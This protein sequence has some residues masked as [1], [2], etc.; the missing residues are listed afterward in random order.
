MWE[1]NYSTFYVCCFRA[2]FEYELQNLEE[3]EKIYKYSSPKVLR[4]IEAIY[5][6]KPKVQPEVKP[7]KKEIETQSL[8]T[9]CKPILGTEQSV[10]CDNNAATVQSGMVEA[11]EIDQIHLNAENEE[12]SNKAGC[13]E[14]VIETN[15][16]PTSEQLITT[17]M[18]G[19]SIENQ[20]ETYIEN[21][22]KDY[23]LEIIQNGDYTIKNHQQLLSVSDSPEESLQTI[24]STNDQ[25][26]NRANKFKNN[27]LS[28]KNQ[29]ESIQNGDLPVE[30]QLVFSNKS[31]TVIENKA[32]SLLNGV[33]KDN[34]R[35]S[36]KD[37]KPTEETPLNNCSETDCETKLNLTNV[38]QCCDHARSEK[39]CDQ[40]SSENICKQ[41]SS[42]KIC[43]EVSSKQIYEQM[44]SEESCDQA[45]TEKSCGHL[46]TEKMCEQAISEQASSEKPTAGETEVVARGGRWRGRGRGWRYQKKNF[47]T[48]RTHRTGSQDDA[49]QLCAIIF[50]ENPFT[51]KILFHLFNVSFIVINVYTG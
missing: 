45:S 14:K 33:S 5:N 37:I 48:T 39:S 1:I 29:S 2:I 23:K 12:K 13:V 49:E 42:K 35:D 6:F 25:V 15:Q 38:E 51:A 17:S 4:L 28:N 8:D 46:S 9:C 3:K 19:L 7:E 36:L 32:H 47:P 21:I 27:V 18:N 24:N 30:D 50:V 34:C 16:M 44:S 20:L 11:K 40:A 22:N 41:A 26:E 31:V 10:S 43:N